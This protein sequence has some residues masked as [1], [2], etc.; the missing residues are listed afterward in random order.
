VYRCAHGCA[1]G[2]SPADNDDTWTFVGRCAASAL[3]AQGA[4]AWDTT[5]ELGVNG[6][7][8]DDWRCPLLTDHEKLVVS[9]GKLSFPWQLRVY[10]HDNESRLDVGHIDVVVRADGT[11]AVQ[12]VVT[13][14]SLPRDVEYV[15]QG[16]R[17]PVTIDYLK[18]LRPAVT[19]YVEKSMRDSSYGVGRRGELVVTGHDNGG[20]K[21]SFFATDF[22]DQQF[23][24]KDG[25]RSECSDDQIWDSNKSY[26]VGKV[27]TVVV[28]GVRRPYTCEQSPRC[29]AG[30]RPD[31][32]GTAW[33]KENR[34]R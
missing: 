14:T 30:V 32:G 28:G 12:P 19:F 13:A 7:D 11:S 20:C 29:D 24:E 31:R 2:K 15:T 22:Q 3:P 10:Q 8:A 26:D 34:C 1:T 17:A 6:Q 18:S 27:A 16:R 21:V 23:L 9:H 33:H 5:Y 25:W 4:A